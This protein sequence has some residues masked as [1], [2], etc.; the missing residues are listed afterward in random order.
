M[1]RPRN[2][3]NYP[4]TPVTVTEDDSPMGGTVES[5][6]AFG[7]IGISNV[8]A[9]GDGVRLFGS[10]LRGHTG[11]IKITIHRAERRHTIARDWYFARETVAE[12]WLSHSQLA[13]MITTPNQGDGVPCTIVRVRG[14]SIPT[15]IP[16]ETE[17]EKIRANVKEKASKIV[18]DL[19][20]ARARTEKALEGVP[21][22]VR[23][24]ALAE[25]DRAITE[26]GS[27]LPY[28]AESLNESLEHS[29]AE[30]KAEI[31]AFISGAVRAAGLKSIADNN[32]MLSLPGPVF[33]DP[34]S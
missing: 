5:H 21:A 10:R 27:N 29:T 34:K 28:Y 26:V 20:A 23:N 16:T 32:G 2:D 13:E 33:E 9:S 3:S 17:S 4:E 25:F 30:A 14:E 8:N 1:S 11:F 6:P 15:F 22:K 12:V 18:A 19:R 7:M 31:E 24:A